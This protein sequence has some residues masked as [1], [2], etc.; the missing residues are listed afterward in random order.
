MRDIPAERK[1][2]FYQEF[3]LKISSSFLLYLLLPSFPSF[4]PFFVSSLAE[5][6]PEFIH[7]T[8][9]YRVIK[10]CKMTHFRVYTNEQK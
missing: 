2:K 6:C 1:F 3:P 8:A 7:E 4:F 5:R 9:L 10:N